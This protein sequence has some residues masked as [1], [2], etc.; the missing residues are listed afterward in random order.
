LQDKLI[1]AG[2]EPGD[3]Q[4]ALS[5]LQHAKIYAHLYADV[6]LDL[7]LPPEAFN[8]TVDKACATG[9]TSKIAAAYMLFLMVIGLSDHG[10]M[11]GSTP[12]RGFISGNRE[13]AYSFPAIRGNRLPGPQRRLPGGPSAPSKRLPKQ[14]GALT[15]SG[16]PKYDP[17]QKPPELDPQKDIEKLTKILQDPTASKVQK[18]SAATTLTFRIIA[19]LL[20]LTSDHP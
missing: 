16:P 17:A 4:A 5:R 3:A 14:K 2:I 12:I 10:D 19:S 20:G 8:S 7:L 15:P 6:N 1:Y 11:P 18:A 13:F 9:D